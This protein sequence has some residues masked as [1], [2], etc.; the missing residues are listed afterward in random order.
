MTKTEQRKQVRQIAKQLRCAHKTEVGITY[1]E[2]GDVWHYPISEMPLITGD[3]HHLYIYGYR[4]EGFGDSAQ[5]WIEDSI[6]LKLTDSGIGV[7][8]ESNKERNNETVR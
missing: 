2:G 6:D 1:V 4:R 8:S 3:E 7:S 5:F